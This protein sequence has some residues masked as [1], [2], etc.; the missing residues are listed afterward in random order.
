MTIHISP[1]I[2]KAG[3]FA[4]HKHRKR[5]DDDGKDYFLYHI[6]NVVNILHDVTDNEAIIA[7][8]YL[9]DI[10][11]DTDTTLEELQKE[12]GD[13][14]ANLVYEVTHVGTKDNKGYSFP[15]LKSRDAIMIKFADRLSN[16]AR[17]DSW[18]DKR[19]QQYLRQSVFWRA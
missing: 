17:M 19:K 5:L 7:A 18:S 4:S 13:K 12:F 1:L 6:C 15:N 2:Q 11:E 14:V 16:I 8:A 10:L 9:H 3:T